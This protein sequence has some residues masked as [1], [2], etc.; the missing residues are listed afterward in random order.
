MRAIEEI[1][2]EGRLGMVAELLGM[3]DFDD[4]AFQFLVRDPEFRAAV[5]KAA[6]KAF[7]RWDEKVAAIVAHV[8][9]CRWC[10]ERALSYGD[11]DLEEQVRGWRR[12]GMF[13]NIEQFACAKTR[14]VIPINRRQPNRA[15]AKS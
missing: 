7:R 14:R 2:Q 8:S 4:Q 9:R 6:Q 12:V 15:R 11:Q 1:A 10:R 13:R 5:R 3:H